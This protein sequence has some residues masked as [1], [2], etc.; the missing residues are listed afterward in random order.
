MT[1]NNIEIERV[2]AADR[3]ATEPI[4]ELENI[5]KRFGMVY[6]IDELSM[7]I[8]PGELRA[9]IGPNGAGKTTLFHVISGVYSPT[10]GAV[11]MYDE[12][13]TS[14]PVERRSQMGLTRSYQNNELFFEETVFE[15]VRIAVQTATV[16]DFDLS[17]FAD[18]NKLYRSEAEEIIE[19]LGLGDEKETLAKNLSHGD[20]RRLGIAIALATDPEILLLDEPT[21]GM[22]AE[23]TKATASLIE[24]VHAEMDITIVIIEHDMSVVMGISDK[25]SVLTDGRHI[26]T[27]EP[28]DIKANEEVRRA[29]LGGAR[30]EEL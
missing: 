14:L 11:R 2:E 18:A 3:K 10:E 4:L 17:L 5:T 12:D 9:I 1:T 13:V 6:A 19:R 30:E 26:A 28:E 25:I 15:N 23:E 20:Q 21:S 24:G 29:Y 8:A 7:R 16:G 22:G 27:G